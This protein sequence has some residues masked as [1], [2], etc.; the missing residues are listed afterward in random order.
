MT[1]AL[2]YLSTRKQP[3]LLIRCQIEVK[4]AI[5][6]QTFRVSILSFDLRTVRTNRIPL[7]RAGADT[8]PVYFERTAIKINRR[9]PLTLRAKRQKTL[10][11]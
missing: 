10:S 6:K 3:S 7:T 2:N 4:L 5:I 1:K 9:P 8:F 11:Q